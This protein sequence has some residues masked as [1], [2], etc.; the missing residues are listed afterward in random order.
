M[1]KEFMELLLKK[2]DEVAASKNVRFVEIPGQPNKRLREYNGQIEEIVVDKPN[3]SDV[4]LS[5]VDLKKVIAAHGDLTKLRLL[6][7]QDRISLTLDDDGY[8]KNTVTMQFLDTA[9]HAFVMKHL[10]PQSYDTDSFLRILRHELR[11]CTRQ[12]E[13]LLAVR[14]VK[15]TASE[16]EASKRSDSQDSLGIETEQTVSYGEGELPEQVTLNCALFSNPGENGDDENDASYEFTFSIEVDKANRKFIL[17]VLKDEYEKKVW[18]A[19][20]WIRSELELCFP[21]LPI[22]YG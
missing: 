6:L 4:V 5:V 16:T 22:F 10:T 13:A 14:N 2:A 17:R 8:R 15:W 9:A 11:F 18:E 1:L 19:I 3:R 12:L 21:S 7:N 20:G